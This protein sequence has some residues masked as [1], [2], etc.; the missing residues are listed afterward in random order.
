[1]GIKAAKGTW[2][3]FLDDDII[4]CKGWL[5]AL[6]KEIGNAK[7]TIVGI[8]GRVIPLGNGVW[9]K[10]VQ[11]EIGGLYL[12][13]NCMYRSDVLR[14][15]EGFDEGFTSKYPSCEDHELAA[16]M[17][18][19]G[20]I[21]FCKDMC[22]NHTPRAISLVT[23]VM[24]SWSR[25]AMQL[26]AEYLFYVKQ[27]DR[28]H[29]FRYHSCFEKTLVATATKHTLSTF[30]RRGIKV[31]VLHPIQVFSL[32]LSCIIEQLCAIVLL[33]PL[34]IKCFKTTQGPF[35]VAVDWLQTGKS[36]GLTRNP[37]YKKYHCKKSLIRSLLFPA[38]HRPS[39]ATDRFYSHIIKYVKS[40]KPNIFLRID[41]VFLDQQ[42]KVKALCTLCNKYR[43]PFL[44]AVPA[45]YLHDKL[46]LQNVEEICLKN[47]DIGIHG[48]SHTG[49][50]GPYPSELLQCTYSDLKIK[51]NAAFLSLKEF[52]RPIAFVPPFNAISSYQILELAKQY[53]VICGGPETLRYTDRICGLCRITNGAWF[54]PSL[55]PLYGSAKNILNTLAASKAINSCFPVCLTVHMPCEAKNNYTDLEQLLRK[56]SEHFISWKTLLL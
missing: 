31:L 22:V 26:S 44:A 36:I 25:M 1:L 15:E 29:C 48:F 41:D 17:Q 5:N 11:N 9:D 8:E 13:C 12:T 56:F 24:N 21:L 40:K 4:M 42:E 2:T 30:K 32:F 37:C 34:L 35:T 55:F 14:I 38:T 52:V 43:V 19:H 23:Y 33:V 46:L 53:P 20:T 28:Y 45:K 27:K 51:T 39:Y 50:F 7:E 6:Q 54:F 16:R 3:C 47:G 49:S 10:E 18:R